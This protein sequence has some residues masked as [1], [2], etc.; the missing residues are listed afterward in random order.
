M[1]RGRQEEREYSTTDRGR[2]E[3]L[4]SIHVSSQA[5]RPATPAAAAEGLAARP[6]TGGAVLTAASQVVVAVVGAVATITIARL[7]GPRGTGG[8][9]VAQSLVLALTVLTTL[10]FEQGI[11]F[12][13]SSSVWDARAASRTA[14]KAAI[15]M[16]AVGALI[17]LCVR[18]LA[19]SPFAHL[20]L[21]LTAVVVSGI[22]FAL[23]WLFV[24]SIALAI[25]RYEAYALPPAL[26]SVFVL[27]FA[28]PGAALFG[29]TGA[30]I[31][32]TAASVFVGLGSGLWAKARIPPTSGAVFQRPVRRAISFGVKGYASNALQ[33]VN[34]RLDIFVLAAVASTAVV[35][36]YAV[37]VAVTSMLW[38]LPNA[39][40]AVLFP[41]VAQ[42]S[43]GDQNAARSLVEAKSLRHASLLVALGALGLVAVLE[44][45]VVP[46]FGKAFSAAITPGLILIPGAASVG[47]ST[48]L[49]STLS[50]RAR[51]IYPLYVALISTPITV[52]LYAG[53]IPWLHA[54]GA[55]LA[56]TSS[57]LVTFGGLC[58]FY[59]RLTGVSVF[60]LLV[61][62]HS[63]LQD[64]AALPR[65]IAERIGTIRR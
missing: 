14:L 25:D 11:T 18:G 20:P 24:T 59:R 53:L 36:R 29:L 42:L 16:G 13:V 60:P 19:S 22:P 2:V 64:L 3:R 17:G 26:Q 4:P 62:T 6:L 31:G 37:A 56:S 51:P 23:T 34:Y 7:L 1:D 58:F 48:I 39:L 65:A 61:P 10:G 32:M 5:G 41:R 52:C 9:A 27:T 30:V 8:Y 57:Y 28:V 33:L 47:I 45:L 55:A 35:G 38:L 43:A 21:W 49:A 15:V 63:E 54:N 46:V 40:A 44:L 12:F 50:G